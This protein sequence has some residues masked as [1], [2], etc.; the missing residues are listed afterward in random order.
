MP[1]ATKSGRSAPGEAETGPLHVEPPSVDQTTSAFSFGPGLVSDGVGPSSQATTSSSVAP[2]PVGAPLAIENAGAVPSRAPAKPS[3]VRSPV[4]GSTMPVGMT[5]VI[6]CCG[7]GN[8]FAPLLD[9]RINSEC[10]FVLLPMPSRP[11]KTLPLL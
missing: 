9:L 8:E 4:F 10:Y 7:P 1:I 5:G 11:K 6:T 3:N 2:T